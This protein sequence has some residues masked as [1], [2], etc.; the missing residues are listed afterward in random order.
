MRSNVYNAAVS[1]VVSIDGYALVSADLSG[2]REQ[3]VVSSNVVTVC[4]VQFHRFYTILLL[5]VQI[6]RYFAHVEMVTVERI[7]FPMSIE[8]LISH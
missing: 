5:S 3:R 7:S 2:P 4:V 6:Q 8:C 1:V